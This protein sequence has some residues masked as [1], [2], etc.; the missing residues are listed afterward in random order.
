M[1]GKYLFHR[2]RSRSN[3]YRV[4]IVLVLVIGGLFIL[5]SYGR[6][7]VKPLFEPSPTPTRTSNSYA[8][9]GQTH[10][11]A[12]NLNASIDAYRQ[13]LAT[14]P[15]NARIWAEL[16]QIETYS[17]NL[18]TTLEQR[19]ERMK[20]ALQAAD[21]AAQLAPDDSSI[22]AIRAFVL[23]WTASYQET[24]ESTNTLIEAEKAAQRALLLDQNNVLA[25]AYSAEIL[26]DQQKWD[27]ADQY[28]GQAVQRNPDL[29]D[30]QRVRAAILE[31]FGRYND[32]ISAYEKAIQLAPNL[33]FLY[34]RVGKIYRYLGSIST[35]EMIANTNYDKALEYYAR[36]V[37]LNKQL[38]IE[39]PNPYLAIGKV[40]S[41]L[42][43]FYVAS[44]N[45]KKAVQIDP[46]SPDLYA[47]LG[48]VYVKA[49]NY[50]TSLPALQCAVEGCDAVLSCSVR[51]C[52]PEKDTPIVIQ[53]MPLSEATVVY[54]YTYGSILAGLHRPNGPT[55]AYCTRAMGVLG[56]VR[57]KFA[58]NRD[59]MSIVE[60]SESL[61]AAY[62]SN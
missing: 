58:A 45:V 46:T 37:E 40:Y 47:E 14:D 38:G 44:R 13:A 53:N 43:Q 25:L 35:E 15:N 31:S 16:A 12:G 59:I 49:R 42:G 9:E 55:S 23:D 20:D 22:H 18:L 36:A 7:E 48:M 5:R 61:C 41:Q 34:L 51:D 50:E 62:G 17:S 1:S 24:V 26:V 56:Q 6:G 54:Y 2:E 19:R 10:F 3:P 21:R 27:Q 28:I 8:L 60:T 4:L 33:T 52:D 11:Q 57:A 30:V 29:M 39:D 32:A